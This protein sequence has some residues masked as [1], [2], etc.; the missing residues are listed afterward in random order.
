MGS[1][2]AAGSGTMIAK[3]EFLNNGSEALCEQ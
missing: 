3:R 1:R 2:R